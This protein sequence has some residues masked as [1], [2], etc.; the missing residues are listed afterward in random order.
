MRGQYSI[1]FL[2]ILVFSSLLFLAI[3]TQSI[4][5]GASLKGGLSERDSLLSAKNLVDSVNSLCVMADG[6]KLSLTLLFPTEMNC[7]YSGDLEC[8]YSSRGK[9]GSFKQKLYCPV[10]PRKISLGGKARLILENSRGSVFI[11]TQRQT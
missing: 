7:S 3:S 9:P 4:S 1:E 5:I 11:S 10:Y 6:S 8:T 2:V